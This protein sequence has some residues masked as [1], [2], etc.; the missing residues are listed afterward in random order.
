MKTNRKD[1][2]RAAYDLMGIQGL[3]SVHARTVAAELNINHATVHYYFRRRTDLLVGVAEHALEQLQID[4]AK[5]QEGM[6]KPADMLEAELALAEA[7]CKK[8]SRFVKVLAGLY[9]ASTSNVI[10]RKN[11]QAI[12][13]EWLALIKDM[14]PPARLKKDSPYHDP[15]A[16]LT[17]LFGIAL[18]SHMLDGK[19]DSKSKIDG[20]YVS[21]FGS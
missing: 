21:M 12:W 16:L 15:E 5:F 13:K 7:Y 8:T 14:T 10:L 17:H 4:R 9:V 2:K 3:E 19:L 1:I 11:L 6:T 18:A 20:I